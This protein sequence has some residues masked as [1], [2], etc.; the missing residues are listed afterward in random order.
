MNRTYGVGNASYGHSDNE[1]NDANHDSDA[2]T[3]C[4]ERHATTTATG[5]RQQ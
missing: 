1:R 4:D 3:K 2:T 5:N